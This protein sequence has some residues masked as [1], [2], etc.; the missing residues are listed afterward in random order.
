MLNTHSPHNDD[1]Q[2]QELARQLHNVLESEAEDARSLA[3]IRERL[4][5]VGKGPL[6]ARPLPSL[7]SPY[8]RSRTTKETS[9]LTNQLFEAHPRLKLLSIAATVI[10][11]IGLV[12]TLSLV[13]LSLR[14]GTLGKPGNLKV[15]SGWSVIASFSG[16][17][18]KT[19]TNLHINLP[20]IWGET[21]TCSGTGDL[22]IAATGPAVTMDIGK[23]SCDTPSD[24]SV[25]QHLSIDLSQQQIERIEIK[26]DA[27]TSW[28][29][30]IAQQ[31]FQSLPLLSSQ[32]IESAGMGGD[33]NSGAA[34]GPTTDQHGKVVHPK[35][36]GLLITCIGTGSGYVDISPTPPSGSINFPTCNGQVA[37]DVLHYRFSTDI[38]SL[39]VTITGK[40]AWAIRLVACANEQQCNTSP[41]T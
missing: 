16:T 20:H 27:S 21:Y 5:E 32:W 1:P 12:G 28:Q 25:P 39:Q 18:N 11:L 7:N 17:G 31:D 29:F 9:M 23:N 38:Q 41:N 10:L 36:W 34:P 24:T 40:V 3:R 37:F 4:L 22:S 6:P 35:T 33:T 2:D 19:F 13:L 14:Q 26:A 30:I 15:H 8:Q